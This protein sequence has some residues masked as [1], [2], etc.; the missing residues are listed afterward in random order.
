MY[1]RLLVFIL[2]HADSFNLCIDMNIVI[3]IHSLR[4]GGAERTVV[5]LANEWLKCGNQV[6]VITLEDKSTDFY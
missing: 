1:G 2:L 5:N 4:R 3:F 6:T